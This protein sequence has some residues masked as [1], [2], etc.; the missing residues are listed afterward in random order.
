VYVA[1]LVICV[2]I[3]IAAMKASV[4]IAALIGI[5]IVIGTLVFIAIMLLI[6]MP[7]SV[8]FRYFSLDMLKNADPSAVQYSGKIGAQ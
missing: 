5:C 2:I 6:A 1:L 4:L 3:A 8:Y 7:V